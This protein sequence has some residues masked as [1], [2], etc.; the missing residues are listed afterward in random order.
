MS[1]MTKPTAPGVVSSDTDMCPV[2][3]TNRYFNKDM[4]FLINPECYHPMCSNCVNRLFK[5]APNQC[6]Y[7]DCNKTLRRKG[8]RPPWFADLAVEREVDIRKRVATVFNMREDDFD[9]LESYNAYLNE[10]EDLTFDLVFATDDKVRNA[11]EQ[12][13]KAYEAEH[14]AQIERNKKAGKAADEASRLRMAAEREAARQRQATALREAAEE[15]IRKVQDREEALD[16][17]TRAPEGVAGKV[18]LKRRNQKVAPVQSQDIPMRDA[19]P[20]ATSEDTTASRMSIFRGLKEKPKPVRNEGPYDVF[21]GGDFTPDRYKL[22]DRISLP[23]LEEISRDQRF[24][25]GG[26]DVRDYYARAMYDAFAG[27]GVFV[28]EEKEPGGLDMVATVGAGMAAER[29]GTV[30]RG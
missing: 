26:Y 15:R 28:G 2:C 10:V 22:Q 19:A 30:A 21:A 29:A 11:A 23:W 9:T 25:V 14:K 7:A 5:D 27:L 3:K 4:E 1:R 8:F 12:R 20:T 24:L 18:M 16:E 6:P 13:L 17:L